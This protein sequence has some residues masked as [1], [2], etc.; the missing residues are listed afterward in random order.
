MEQDHIDAM[1]VQAETIL[2][3]A[4]AAGDRLG[5]EGEVAAMPI[6]INALAMAVAD[7]VGPTA[8]SDDLARAGNIACDQVFDLLPVQWSVRTRRQGATP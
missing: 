1:M 4:R 7:F 2:A 3:G 6:L 5:L 8:T